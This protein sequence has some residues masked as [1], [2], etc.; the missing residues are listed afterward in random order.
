MLPL[1]ILLV[2]QDTHVGSLWITKLLEAQQQVSAFFQFDGGQCSR[3]RQ[4]PRPRGTPQLFEEGCGCQGAHAGDKSSSVKAG[5]LSKEDAFCHGQCTAPP[6]GAPCKAVLA[7]ADTPRAREILQRTRFT[8]PPRLVA[9]HRDN[10]AKR[11]VSSLKADC[12]ARDLS[13]HATAADVSNVSNP[14]YLLIDP[15]LF[16]GEAMSSARHQQALLRWFPPGQVAHVTHYE[17]WQLNADGA[18]RRL[19]GDLGLGVEPVPSTHAA[20]RANTRKSAREELRRLLVNFDAIANATAMQW[21][22]LLPQLT[23][24]APRRFEPCAPRSWAAAAPP[25]S[26][27]P[28]AGRSV[29]VHCAKKVCRGAAPRRWQVPFEQCFAT[30]RVGRRLC[31]MALAHARAQRP[32]AAPPAANLCVRT[33]DSRENADDSWLKTSSTGWLRTFAA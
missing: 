5:H 22:C 29:W 6:A 15:Q 21:P 20:A 10:L 31:E 13:N 8:A 33:V 26:P 27:V 7:M 4:P 12:W 23:S 32:G 3:P 9:L 19:L 1:P 14:T 11:A 16:L 18:L 28:G 25:P 30:A 17:D 24:A 2:R